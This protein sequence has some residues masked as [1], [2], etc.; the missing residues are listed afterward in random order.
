MTESTPP[1]PWWAEHFLECGGE[2]YAHG[3]WSATN[4]FGARPAVLVIDATRAFTGFEGQTL[5]ESTAQYPTACG[6]AAWTAMPHLQ[7]VIELANLSRWP[8]IYTKA[9][10][11]GARVYGGTVK[12]EDSGLGSPMELP[13][14]QEFPPAIAPAEDALVLT[15][16]KASAFFDTALLSYLIRHGVDT[17]IVTGATTSGCV[18][19][20]VVDAH[21]RGY[22]T[23][24]VEEAVFDRSRLSHAVNLFEMDAKYADVVTVDDLT[25]LATSSRERR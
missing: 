16:P 2:G 23:Y 6:P 21:S 3:Q 12:S 15:K 24:V 5:K 22:P 9:L 19:A 1:T 11:G 17:I 18:R 10:A 8:V 20:S 7:R 13:G 25:T 4:S 14:A